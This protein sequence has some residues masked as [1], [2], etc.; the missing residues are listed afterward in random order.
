[1]PTDAAGIDRYHQNMFDF[2]RPNAAWVASCAAYL[3]TL[4]PGG[5]KGKRVVDYGFGRGNWS[6]AFLE[7]GASHVTAI[8]ASTDAVERFSRFA[9]DEGIGDLSVQQGNTD[10][11]ELDISA[12][13][14]FLYGILHHV[15]QPLKLLEAAARMCAGPDSLVVVYAYNADSLRQTIAEIGRAAIGSAPD[16]IRDLALTLHPDARIRA[17]DDLTAPFVNFWSNTELAG[18]VKTAGL[19]PIAQTAD[20]AAFEMKSHAPE[21][22]PYLLIASPSASH[23]PVDTTPQTSP[24]GPDLEHLRALADVVLGGLDEPNRV[25]FALGLFNT[26]FAVQGA[27]RYFD[28]VFALWRYLAIAALS[29]GK[30]FRADQLPVTTRS[31]FDATRDRQKNPDTQSNGPAYSD[32]DGSLASFIARGGFRL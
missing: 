25:K 26:S 29:Q 27:D 17:M 8:D 19:N 6:L 22:E 13:V 23:L 24:N 18:M 4:F 15:K 2:D 9:S 16:A 5:L 12:D 7:L 3:S 11:E 28:R 14:I 21:F 31:L 20:F 30:G 1:M 32:I 10:E